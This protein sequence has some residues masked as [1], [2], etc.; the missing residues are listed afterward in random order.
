MNSGA[1]QVKVDQVG[2][3]IRYWRTGS[4]QLGHLLCLQ[5]YANYRSLGRVARQ[6]YKQLSMAWFLSWPDKSFVR[7]SHV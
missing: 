6:A 5:S 1:R 2:V 3:H 4:D 7:L